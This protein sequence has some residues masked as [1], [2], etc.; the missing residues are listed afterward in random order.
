MGRALAALM[1]AEH[2]PGPLDYEAMM[3]PVRTAWVRR[4]TGENL[5]LWYTFDAARLCAAALTSHPPVPMPD[6]T[7]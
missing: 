1:R 3:P 7:H 5:W 6:P 2:L 4:L